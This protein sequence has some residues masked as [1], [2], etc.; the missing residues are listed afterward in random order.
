MKDIWNVIVCE[1]DFEDANYLLAD[2]PSVV[3]TLAIY[4]SPSFKSLDPFLLSLESNLKQFHNKN[5]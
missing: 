2:I 1:P 3:T 4:R 5:Q